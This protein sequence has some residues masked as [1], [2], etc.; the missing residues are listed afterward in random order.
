MKRLKRGMEKF[1]SSERSFS[2]FYEFFFD[3]EFAQ[4]FPSLSCTKDSAL[5]CINDRTKLCEVY[6]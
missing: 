6:F 2:L 3:D 1:M 5:N 4:K